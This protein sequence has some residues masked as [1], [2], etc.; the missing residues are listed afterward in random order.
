MTH[1]HP[2]PEPVAFIANIPAQIEAHWNPRYAYLAGFPLNLLYGGVR[3]GDGE[4]HPRPT[5]TCYWFDPG[6]Y[7]EDEQV[8]EML[9]VPREESAY[10]VR[11][12]LQK[13]TGV[14]TTYKYR[15]DTLICMASGPD[16]KT[17]MLHTTMVGRQAD[18]SESDLG[19]PA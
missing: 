4:G 3:A 6:T 17:A 13:D 15:G 12:T 7:R 10:Y 1:Q 19:A 9:Y 2:T 18:E 16:F 5:A 8:R 11:V 14:W